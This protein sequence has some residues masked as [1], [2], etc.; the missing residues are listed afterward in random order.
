MD[1]IHLIYVWLLVSLPFIILFTDP[2]VPLYL[3]LRGLQLAA[4]IQRFGVGLRLRASLA[5]TRRSF[6]NDWLGR[7]LRALELR[8][9]RRNPAYAEF[10]EPRTEPLQEGPD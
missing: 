1:T 10:F 4:D 9:I 3:E 8:A 6:R 5:C 7:G 2:N